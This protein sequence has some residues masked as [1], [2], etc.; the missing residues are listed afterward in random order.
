MNVKSYTP[1]A[2]RIHRLLHELFRGTDS[3]TIF[4]AVLFLALMHWAATDVQMFFEE[5][6]GAVRPI[7]WA[8]FDLLW[9]LLSIVMIL[10]Y[11]WFLRKI[12]SKAPGGKLDIR[13]EQFAKPCK[14]LIVFLSRPR[15][16]PEKEDQ[17]DLLDSL[18]GPNEA[19]GLTIQANRE[20]LRGPWRMP[21]EAVAHHIATLKVLVVVFPLPDPWLLASGNPN[22]RFCEL[23]RR[24][25]QFKT[26]PPKVVPLTL[27]RNLES[28][29]NLLDPNQV[30]SAVEG[31]KRIL[32]EEESLRP[33]EIIIDIT[34]GQKVT[35]GIAAASA[36]DDRVR[37]Q[38]VDTNS[39][40]VSAYDLTYVPYGKESS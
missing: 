8:H 16:A 35:S 13:V 21:I 31:A 12:A 33:E 30:L 5:Y 15:N 29:I 17:D 22:L 2:Q 34:G 18:G 38:Y 7:G 26:D 3:R 28:G 40:K 11:I 4:L 25:T 37:C 36:F 20:K 39:Y 32:L 23:V 9:H 10:G 19:D 14:G 6:Y 1:Q 24:L 27:D